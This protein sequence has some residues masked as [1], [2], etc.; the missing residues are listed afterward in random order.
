MTPTVPRIA[1]IGDVHANLP[2]LGR[3]LDRVHSVGVQGI[4]LVGDLGSNDVG[5]ARNRTPGGDASYRSSVGEV[6]DRVRRL[7]LPVMWVPGNHDLP[8]IG[9]S[10]EDASPLRGNVDGRV[11][12]MAGLRITGLGGA[13]PDRFGFCYEWSDEELRRRA[14]PDAD[15]LLC[16]CPPRGTPLDSVARGVH[17]GSQA[18][19][20]IAERWRGVL[21]CGHIHEAGGVFRIGDCLCLNAGGLGRPYGADRIGFIEGTDAVIYEDLA[22]GTRIELRR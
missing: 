18:I 12:I 2:R 10:A 6:L 20:E 21:V 1:V 16:H 4:L 7:G 3:V 14:V 22:A 5:F 9:R 13:G 8:D 19:R 15:V 11:A 17:V